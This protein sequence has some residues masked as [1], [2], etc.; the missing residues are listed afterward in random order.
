MIQCY[1][2]L[3]PNHPFVFRIPFQDE[4]RCITG[5]NREYVRTSPAIKETVLTLLEDLD[6]EEWVY[7]CIDD[8]YPI[9][10]H[11][12]Q[13]EEIYNS[14]INNELDEIS[15]LLFCRT[16]KMLSPDYL[17]GEGILIR[18]EKLIE[19]K[20]YHQIWIHQFVKVKIIRY[21]FLNFPDIIEKP[22]ILD[23]LK[24]KIKKPD[25]HKLFVTSTNHSIFG[26]SSFFGVI[27]ENCYRSMSERGINIP[28]WFDVDHAV[29]TIIGEL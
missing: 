4:N 28:S 11:V 29:S 7:W 15:G 21:L 19:R 26:E 23:P 24:H 27:T 8:K 1:D 6:D 17:T 20:G 12:Q 25:N 5:A 16:R 2:E 9:Q 13:I 10:L 3:W 18:N 22:R 14:I